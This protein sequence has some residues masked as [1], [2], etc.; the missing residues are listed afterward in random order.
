MHNDST[1]MIAPSYGFDLIPVVRHAWWAWGL[2]MAQHVC[3]LA[4]F[5][6]GFVVDPLA[7]FSV[8][9]GLGFWCL[10]RLLVRSARV[11]LPL[12][13]KAAL[14]RWLRKTR[15][16]SESEE[17]RQ[18]GRLL[19]LSSTGC[20]VLIV[21]PP[22]IAVFSRV[23]LDHMTRATAFLA[24]LIAAVVCGRGAVYQWRLNR[25]HGADSLEPQKLTLRQMA[26]ADQQSHPYVVYRRPASP[27][28][29]ADPEDLV[30]ELIDEDR[31][32]FVGSG[33]LVHRWLPPL[34]VQLLRSV[35]GPEGLK[36]HKPMEELEPPTPRFE[37]H[38]LVNYLKAAMAPMGDV[39]D[40]NGLR[41][42]TMR[43]RL[44]IAEADVPPRPDWLRKRPEPSDIDKI[45]DDP[46]GAVHHFLEIG[47]SATGELV[48]TVFL[49]VT[50][51]GRALSLDFAACALTRTPA[52]YHV[53]NA[54][55]ENGVSAVVR[56]ALK[57]LANLPLEVA[58][59]RRL[60][61]IPLLLAGAVRARKN[62]M[63][64]PRRGMAIGAALSIRE[65]KS[66]PW[67]H[68]QLDEVTIHDHM[69]LIEQRLLKA[70]ED[71]LELHEL[72][73]SA[74]QKRATS[75]VNT[76]VLNMGGKTEIK[77]SAIGT[78][79]QVRPDARE[80]DKNAEQSS[81]SQGDE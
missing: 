57:G 7:T 49:R 20:A 80:P 41:G 12:R 55:A 19:R 72:D 54:F 46:Y 36:K 71:F 37:A 65:E 44:Y 76:G 48:T 35:K 74:F 1:R 50:V 39:N 33:E 28:L 70:V 40:P 4:V 8:V 66:T 60:A 43:D 32:P 10:S 77:Q 30:F 69:K 62:R 64:K 23:P 29:E 11:V 53:L 81:K 9:S 38:E 34:T 45:I 5:A 17:L 14:K 52:E 63:L 61:E 22:L 67:K 27:V 47:A 2:E 75:I 59:M 18:Q 51:K 56:S 6:T 26:M 13:A 78:N 42:F 79:A 25:M 58:G 16:Q 73:T 15:W 68:A 24:L 21:L 31:S 3:V